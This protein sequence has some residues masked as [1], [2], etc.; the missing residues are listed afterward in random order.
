MDTADREKR[1]E[2]LR[3][4]CSKML[5]LMGEDVGLAH[6][7]GVVILVFLLAHGYHF[8]AEGVVRIGHAHAHVV[9]WGGRVVQL[10]LSRE[11]IDARL[12]GQLRFVV[13]VVDLV[14]LIEAQAYLVAILGVAD[15]SVEKH[16]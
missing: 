4:C 9:Q 6:L 14:S 10:G 2:G 3:E 16:L 15:R 12:H 11:V 1:L 13:E 8:G 7:L 5:Q